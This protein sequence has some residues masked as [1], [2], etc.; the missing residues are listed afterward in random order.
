MGE[1]KAQRGDMMKERIE[2]VLSEEIRPMLASHGGSVELVEVTGDNVVKVRLTGGCAGC[3]G[4]QMTL[5][6]VVEQ[7]LKSRIP[8]VN[9]VEAVQ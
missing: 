7:T 2:K 6:G 5:T 4:A 1:D 3:P 8:E 9:K